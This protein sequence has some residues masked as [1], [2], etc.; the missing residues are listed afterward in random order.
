M[1]LE[2]E[3]ENFYKLVPNKKYYI[4]SICDFIGTF[5]CYINDECYYNDVAVFRN[6]EKILNVLETKSCGYVTFIYKIERAFYKIKSQKERIQNEMETR[7]L[8]K[9]L[10]KITGDDNFIW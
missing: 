2:F 6:V 7:A 1:P 9:I 10:K 3:Q 8:H 4:T 5:E